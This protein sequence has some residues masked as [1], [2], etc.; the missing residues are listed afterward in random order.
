MTICDDIKNKLERYI[1]GELSENERQAVNQHLATCPHC[2]REIDELKSIQSIGRMTL[3]PEPDTAYWYQLRENIRQ[4]IQHKPRKVVQRLVQ[5]Q[6]AINWLVPSKLGYRLIGLTA[7]AVVAFFVIQHAFF[8]K[9]SLQESLPR[10]TKSINRPAA[11]TSAFELAPSADTIEA[12]RLPETVE[13]EKKIVPPLDNM[14]RSTR[15]N[16]AESEHQALME[17]TALRPITHENLTKGD[18]KVFETEFSKA[19][20]KPTLSKQMPPLFPQAGPTKNHPIEQDE[21]TALNAMTISEVSSEKKK[22]HSA[23]KY[24]W[25]VDREQHLETTAT[26]IE[27]WK[28]YLQL[29]QELIYQQKAIH[30]LARLYF[31]LAQQQRDRANI[32]QALNFYREHAALLNAAPDSTQFRSSLIELEHMLQKTGKK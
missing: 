15:L 8:Q 14:K 19:Q 1:D 18:I 16:N 10:Y 23:A 11:D 29:E 17:S 9:G 30:Q 22:L 27:L 7:A 32:L 28:K 26:K 4:R 20:V 21:S 2:S 5:W 31:E 3:F 25:F 12:Q 6:K 13:D 24:N